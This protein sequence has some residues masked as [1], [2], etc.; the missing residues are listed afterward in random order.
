[1][2]TRRRAFALILL[3][4][5]S[6]QVLMPAYSAYAIFGIADIVFDPPTEAETTLTAASS[7]TTAGASTATAAS[8]GATAGNTAATAGTSATTAANASADTFWK[9]VLNVAAYAA[10][11]IVLQTITRQ[12]I[13]WI[14]GRDS[15]FV[16][17]IQAETLRTADAETGRLLNQLTGLNL[18][19]NIGAFLKL[20][21][22]APEASFR[23]RMQCSV[24]GI[25]G[26]FQNFYDNF[27]N[28]GWPAFFQISL[29]PQ[30]NAYGAFLLAAGVEAERKNGAQINLLQSLA[31]G[32]GFTGFKVP[33]EEG[34]TPVSDTT[35][36]YL[37]QQLAEQKKDGSKPNQ[38][39]KVTK[40]D[41][42]DNVYESCDVVYDTKTPGKLFADALPAAT[43]SGL[44]RTELATQIDQGIAQIITALLQ[45]IIQE[46][47]GGGKG[48]FGARDL[49][50]A[51]TTTLADAGFHPTYIVN[52]TDGSALRLEA[53]QILIDK[54]IQD[55]DIEIAAATTQLQAACIG[56]ESEA[57]CNPQAI[58]TQGSPTEEHDK[59][60]FS[61]QVDKMKTGSISLKEQRTKQVTQLQKANGAIN[62]IL[63]L[64]AR[65]LTTVDPI[66]LENLNTKLVGIQGD[67]EQIIQQAGGPPEGQIGT[68]PDD[69][70]VKI[71]DNAKDRATVIVAY[72]EK[73]IVAETDTAKKAA[74]T[75]ARDDLKKLADD[76]GVFRTAFLDA[77]AKEIGTAGVMTQITGKIGEVNDK[78]LSV[79]AL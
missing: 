57:A 29:E 14:Q 13:G 59:L 40:L 7:A 33:R 11:N 50:T 30:N 54:K 28:G 34:C 65:M 32:N 20:S 72:L 52:Q 24:T 21:I 46:S 44:R 22:G 56:H 51:P 60:V 48:L 73:R 55:M 26:N 27:A 38:S 2:N 49:G 70:F 63:D 4:T 79:Y 64:R 76:L 15:G 43:F 37:Q 6:I 1:M 16:Q 25:V 71:A 75:K 3:T 62:Q 23:Q 18:C 69:N 9:R 19:G 47:V 58:I 66:L 42:G 68:D 31:Q 53:S 17:N 78:I 67:A 39:I 12:I 10:I 5:F 77:L 74:L 8:S 35:G 61:L 41:T 36:Q 45:R